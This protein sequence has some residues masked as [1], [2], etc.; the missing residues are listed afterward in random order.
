MMKI[1]ALLVGGLA[2]TFALVS[3]SGVSGEE[4]V[5]AEPLANYSQTGSSPIETVK[6]YCEL[7]L[8]GNLETIKEIVTSLPDEYIR[9]IF[10]DDVDRELAINSK[11]IS[12]EAIRP[13]SFEDRI[14]GFKRSFAP[15]FYDL[16]T[17]DYPKDIQRF[18]FKIA[19]IKA[20]KVNGD[21]AR[22]DANLKSAIDPVYQM[23]IAFFLYRDQKTWKMFMVTETALA[24]DLP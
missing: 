1:V 10:K 20:P 15:L 14:S 11:S 18:Q 12:P 13:L 17:H 9:L 23:D 6:Q 24:E 2:V 5:T 16:L 21:L 7:S 4:D 19:K 8:V 3:M 22:I